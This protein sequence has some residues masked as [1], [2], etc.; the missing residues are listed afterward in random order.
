MSLRKASI[1]FFAAA[2]AALEVEVIRSEAMKL[3]SI[4]MWVHLH[5]PEYHVKHNH[6]EKYWNN[7]NK[8]YAKAGK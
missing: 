6:V 3:V 1:A 2:F 8:K 4:G 7:S 5:N